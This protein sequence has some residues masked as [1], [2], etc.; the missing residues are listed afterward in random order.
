MIPY[1][2]VYDFYLDGA[3]WVFSN[4][5][6]SN[7]ID[8]AWYN[9]ISETS[10]GLHMAR[11]KSTSSSTAKA[12][13]KRALSMT[14]IPPFTADINNI[15]L[16]PADPLDGPPY[17]VAL[18]F[19]VFDPQNSPSVSVGISDLSGVQYGIMLSYASNI[20]L[21]YNIIQ[22]GN[23]VSGGNV[24]YSPSYLNEFEI[25][26]RKPYATFDITELY[27]VYFIQR[28]NQ[29]NI[30]SSTQLF[31]GTLG[32]GDYS[33]K[34]IGIFLHSS[35]VDQEACIAFDYIRLGAGFSLW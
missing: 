17:P 31:Q 21:S 7:I 10:S 14:P 35:A 5:P 30:V 11:L 13:L 20:S 3:T 16:T 32:G 19:F 2:K 23:N 12:F 34:R 18:K 24:S 22:S 26:L 4:A 1:Q 8:K 33:Q 27:E 29:Y 9:T 6:F 25:R 28:D 15:I